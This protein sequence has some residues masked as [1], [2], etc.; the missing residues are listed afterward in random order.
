MVNLIRRPLQLASTYFE[1][2]SQRRR[3]HADLLGDFG[4]KAEGL[5]GQRQ[6]W[7][8]ACLGLRGLRV[9][10]VWSPW[11]RQFG[12]F[13]SRHVVSVPTRLS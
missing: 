13:C 3:C 8:A 10:S 1:R 5:G 2:I 12:I 4:A 7:E 6:R 11:F 9:V